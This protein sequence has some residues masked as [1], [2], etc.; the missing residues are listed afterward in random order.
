MPPLPPVKTGE[1][2]APATEVVPPAAGAP[3]APLSEKEQALS[4]FLTAAE[5]AEKE[6]PSPVVEA[7]YSPW[8]GSVNGGSTSKSG[9]L[10]APAEEPKI[11]FKAPSPKAPP[12]PEVTAAAEPEAEATKP[13][14]KDAKQ[15][16]C[17]CV[18]Q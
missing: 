18:V 4:R 1:A 12:S 6:G 8:V 13:A 2:A 14:A 17:A 11:L 9:R 15:P 3:A 5:T 16:G 7:E 10:N